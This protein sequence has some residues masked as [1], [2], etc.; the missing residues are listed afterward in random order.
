ML[1]AM[2]GLGAVNGSCRGKGY[3]PASSVVL[4]GSMIGLFLQF[5]LLGSLF[6][7]LVLSTQTHLR[8]LDSSQLITS[9]SL[10]V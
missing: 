2:W 5:N 7:G 8:Q 3:N 9:P 10:A 1:A 4:S 6:S